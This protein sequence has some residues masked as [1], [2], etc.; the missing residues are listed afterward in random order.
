M[1]II[2]PMRYNNAINSNSK[3]SETYRFKQGFLMEFLRSEF[4]IDSFLEKW[5]DYAKMGFHIKM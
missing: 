2:Y 1:R 4:L 3:S 5:R